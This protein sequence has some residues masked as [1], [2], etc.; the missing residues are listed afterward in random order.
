MG[1]SSEGVRA[2]TLTR[3][4]RGGGGKREREPEPLLGEILVFP[5]HLCLQI[6]EVLV[7]LFV[8]LHCLRFSLSK[9]TTAQETR[10]GRFQSHSK[11]S[12]PSVGDSSRCTGSGRPLSAISHGEVLRSFHSLRTLPK[13]PQ[14]WGRPRGAYPRNGRMECEKLKE[15]HRNR[16]FYSLKC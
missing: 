9:A 2:V 5:V 15:V 1:V 16:V 4:Q 6:P 11:V 13:C 14:T 12:A 8:R 3:V 10:N 7:V